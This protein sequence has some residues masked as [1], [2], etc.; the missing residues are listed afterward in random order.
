[1]RYVLKEMTI[2]E[3]LD[4]G[5]N[6]AKDNFKPLFKITLILLVP[7]FIAYQIAIFYCIGNPPGMFASPQEQQAFLQGMT[8]NIIPYAMINGIFVLSFGFIIW[9]ITNAA[10]IR[11]VAGAYLGQPISSGA[12]FKE[13]LSRIVPLLGV[14]FLVGLATWFGIILLIV[15]GIY[16]AIRLFLSTYSV[17]IEGTGPTTAMS[18]SWKL[19]EG[20][21]GNGLVLGFIVTMATG[22]MGGMF[23]IIPE[24]HLRA[25]LMGLV[26]GVAMIGTAATGV[27]FYFSCRCKHENF[28]L[29]VLADG[30]G[31][32]SPPVDGLNTIG[33][34]SGGSN[35]PAR[36]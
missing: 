29:S 3:V 31:Q 28:D 8:K 15:P 30:V 10:M 4:V 27:V 2:G 24:P 19:M 26:Q 5:V 9:P 21:M 11:A 17:V 18:R 16:F 35:P 25:V 6:I 14:A 23:S 32:E 22:M 33:T 1:V 7:A 13:G 20:N 36:G 12:A 34:D